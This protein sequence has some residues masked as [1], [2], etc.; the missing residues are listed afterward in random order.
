MSE[1]DMG[2]R[3]AF[4]LCNQLSLDYEVVHGLTDRA[5]ARI[6]TGETSERDVRVLLKSRHKERRRRGLKISSGEASATERA[7]EQC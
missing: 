7:T 1:T 2:K 4:R 5:L 6:A 3:I